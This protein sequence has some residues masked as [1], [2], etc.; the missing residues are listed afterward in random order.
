MTDV[1]VLAGSLNNG[2][3]QSCSSVPYEAMIKIGNQVMV[4]HVVNAML[5]S[6]RVGRVTVVGP[7]ELKKILLPGITL[8]ECGQTVMENL[9]RGCA[10]FDRPVLVAT[11]DIPLLT[12]EAVRGFID[13]CGDQRDDLYFPVV[14]R[15]LVEQ[16]FPGVK[17]TYVRFKEG[18]FTGGNLFLIN[19]LAVEKCLTLGQELVNLRKSP[20][21]LARRV[22]LTLLLKLLFRSLSLAEAQ[23]GASKLLGIKGRAV[24]CPYPETGVDVDKPG[25]LECVCKI[26]EQDRLPNITNLQPSTVRSN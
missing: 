17:R 15:E 19:P 7:P 26:M 3:L 16:R 10:L 2:P 23:A 21:A 25:D 5:Q 24:I 14:P 11:A 6:E 8:V 13:L 22:G 4:N 18:T 20:L 12:P 9:Q 1:L